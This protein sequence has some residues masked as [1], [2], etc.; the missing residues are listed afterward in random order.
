MNIFRRENPSHL[1]PIHPDNVAS[2]DWIVLLEAST[3]I[4]PSPDRLRVAQTTQQRKIVRKFTSLRRH[5]FLVLDSYDPRIHVLY[6]CPQLYKYDSDSKLVPLSGEEIGKFVA[7]A[8]E[9]HVKT[10]RPWYEPLEKLP[11]DRIVTG[12]LVTDLDTLVIEKPPGR[13]ALAP[14]GASRAAG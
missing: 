14:P 3:I 2:K 10:R 9:G 1:V 4:G 13:R 8:V 6:F 11:D 7:Q 12:D 5:P